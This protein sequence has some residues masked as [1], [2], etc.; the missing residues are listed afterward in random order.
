VR[1]AATIF[2]FAS[3]VTPAQRGAFSEGISLN[4]RRR[5]SLISAQGWSAATTLGL[6][7]KYLLN[8]EKGSPTA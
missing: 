5:R 7:Q 2:L 4:L 6:D 1:L 8:P 3:V